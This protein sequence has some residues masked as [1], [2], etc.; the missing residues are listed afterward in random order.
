MDSHH[1]SVK[2]VP[3][4]AQQKLQAAQPSAV[5]DRSSL[6]WASQGAVLTKMMELVMVG[7]WM[8]QAAMRQA[9]MA[10]TDTLSLLPLLSFSPLGLHPPPDHAH[11]PL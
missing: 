6:V 11:R 2:L 1:Q 8:E 3:T 7:L 4:A 9:M 5:S 10:R